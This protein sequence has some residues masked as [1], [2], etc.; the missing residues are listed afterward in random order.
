M[1]D[2]HRIAESP[3]NWPPLLP[4]LL[5]VDLYRA[6]TSSY[7]NRVSLTS[8][9]TIRFRDDAAVCRTYQWHRRET[10][11]TKK[12]ITFGGSSRLTKLDAL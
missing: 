5:V 2:N 1:L 11:A 12:A 10:A 7:Y 6:F 3:T 4:L 9:C 8:T